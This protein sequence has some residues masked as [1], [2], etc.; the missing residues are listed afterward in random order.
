MM[1]TTGTDE[2][3]IEN[4]SETINKKYKFRLTKVDSHESCSPTSPS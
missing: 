1:M 3:A 2:D 4:P